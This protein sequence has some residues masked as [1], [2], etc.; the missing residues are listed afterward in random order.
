VLSEERIRPSFKDLVLSM[1][2]VV[3]EGDSEMRRQLV[4]EVVERADCSTVASSP[5][6]GRLRA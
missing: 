1:P 3:E 6:C 5:T 4:R 2:D